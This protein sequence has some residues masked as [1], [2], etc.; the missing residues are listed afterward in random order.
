MSFALLACVC[1][2]APA[3][4][5]D[6]SADNAASTRTL[7]AATIWQVGPERKIKLPSQ[8]AKFAQPGDTIEIDAAVY[9]NDYAVWRQEN[10]TL[11][12]VGGMA[13]LQSNTL[14]PNGKA[15]WIVSGNNTVSKTLNSPARGLWTPTARASGTRAATSRCAT[16]TSTTMNFPCSPA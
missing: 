7:P 8:A 4:G 2:P 12:G 1:R 11:R 16:P 5:T 14:I 13:H 6:A 10:L 3:R 9:L 15:I